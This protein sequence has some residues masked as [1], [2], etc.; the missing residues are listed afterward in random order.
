MVGYKIG[1][2][3]ALSLTALFIACAP[4]Q[5]MAQVYRCSN[6]GSTYISDRPCSGAPAGRLGMVGPSDRGAREPVASSYVAPVGKAPEHLAF[7]SA[8]CASLNDAIRT[9]PAR[10]LKSS[11]MSDLQL[12]YRRKCQEEESAAFQRLSQQR[13]D[14]RREKQGREKAFQAQ[15]S[16]AQRNREQCDEL[17]RILAAKRRQADGMN[18]GEKA[19]FQRFEASYN[20]RCRS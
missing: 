10:G 4:G 14:D 1:G 2:G 18:T 15:A 5:A 16:E 3:L 13:S 17:L 9:G 19:D 8:E 11:T 7:M 12:E 6:G 20:A